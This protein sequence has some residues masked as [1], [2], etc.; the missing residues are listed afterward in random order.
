MTGNGRAGEIEV[1]EYWA[2]LL[3]VVSRDPASASA[4]IPP[5]L[6][7][8]AVLLARCGLGSQGCSL[9]GVTW[10]ELPLER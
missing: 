10:I 3:D 9:L 2:R 5:H 6:P 7:N 4:S 1:W 8:R